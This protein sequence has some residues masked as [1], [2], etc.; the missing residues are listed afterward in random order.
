MTVKADPTAQAALLELQAQDAVLAQLQ[1]RRNTLPE[2]ARIAELETQVKDVD[3]TRI[4]L[5]T[6]VSELVTDPWTAHLPGTVS[7]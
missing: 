1:H 6:Q 4:E 5:D 2:L 7:L 3:G